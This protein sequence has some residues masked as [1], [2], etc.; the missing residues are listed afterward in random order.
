MRDG[1]IGIIVG[2]LV[3]GTVLYLI[4]KGI[5]FLG[6]LFRGKPSNK[7]VIQAYINVKA[8]EQPDGPGAGLKSKNGF[9]WF[10]WL[11]VSIGLAYLLISGEI[12]KSLILNSQ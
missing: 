11:I 10:F 7:D 4:V 2:V 1:G 12:L 6:T 5:K 3:F 8:S 9:W